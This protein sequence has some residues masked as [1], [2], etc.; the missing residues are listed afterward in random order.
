[1]R[2]LLLLPL[3]LV[4]LIAGA[5][6]AAAQE[7]E[8]TEKESATVEK[9][10][11][12][13]NQLME[14]RKYVEALAAYKEALALAPNADSILFNGG[15]AAYQSKD[16]TTALELWLRLKK[17]D[18]SDWHARAKL[19]QVYQALNKFTDRDAERADL[20][21]IWKSGKNE[22][23]SKQSHYCREQFEV[24]K[25]QVMVFEHFELK[26]DRALRY[27][28]TVLQDNTTKE[29]FR[30]SLGSYEKTNAI[31]RESAK[32]KPGVEDR[33]FHLDGYFPS[34]H[35]TYGMYVREPTYEETRQAV[36]QILKNLRK[37]ISWT[38][39]PQPAP[40]PSPTPTP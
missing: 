11:D 33:L 23:L 9:A 4:W 5:P 28:F 34:R 12:N 8:L 6:P 22:D 38:I 15:L 17:V 26:G 25:Y 36:V 2:R 1:M 19:V 3:V 18:P 16:Y 32:P 37:P 14:Q 24:D 40:T 27:V 29:F 20:I 35:N 31:W 7:R 39:Y 13:A 10:F 21:K 30:I